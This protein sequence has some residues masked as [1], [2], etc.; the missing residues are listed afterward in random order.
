MNSSD[1]WFFAACCRPIGSS[2]PWL[3]ALFRNRTLAGS[4]MIDASGIKLAL[5]RSCTPSPA[6]VVSCLNTGPI[7]R[8]P[9]TQN[10]APRIPALKFSTSISKPGRIRCWTR[11]S[12][13]LSSHALAGPTIIAAKNCALAAPG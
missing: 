4:T 9:S 11:L 3:I 7:T 2:T 12:H 10:S 8:N 5:T 13:S 6:Q 1:W